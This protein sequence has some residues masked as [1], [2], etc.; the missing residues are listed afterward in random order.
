MQSSNER[1]THV[2][3]CQPGK[4]PEPGSPGFFS[5]VGHR[6]SRRPEGR[7]A[8]AVTILSGGTIQANGPRVLEALSGQNTYPS[9]HSRGSLS[10]HRPSLETAGSQWPSL[11]SQPCA[12]TGRRSPGVNLGPPATPRAQTRHP[13]LR[14][15]RD[16]WQGVVCLGG[17]SSVIST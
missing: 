15:W 16:S 6:S 4:R 12:H 1:A 8:F 2:K 7:Q 13:A 9:E 11:L 10:S 17:L 5:G 3:H 14:A